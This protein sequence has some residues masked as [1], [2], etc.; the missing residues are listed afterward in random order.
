MGKELSEIAKELGIES[1]IGTLVSTTESS[2]VSE[3]DFN[4][5]VS[6]LREEN[7]RLAVEN[8]NIK[9]E[10][11]KLRELAQKVIENSDRINN[12]FA[13]SKKEDSEW[14]EKFEK[15]DNA[16]KNLYNENCDLH[17][18][19]IAYSKAVGAIYGAFE[20]LQKELK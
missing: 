5:L 13:S 19:V 10:N 4:K 11:K 12:Y 9:E 6:T 16:R 14:K 8:Q 2:K 15:A 1:L 17:K 3:S 20:T 18:Q 7:G